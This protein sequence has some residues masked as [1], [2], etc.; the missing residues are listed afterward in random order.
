MW[1]CWKFVMY[2]MTFTSHPL[3]VAGVGTFVLEDSP[4]QCVLASQFLKE[5][6]GY[7]SLMYGIIFGRNY[8][9]VLDGIAAGERKGEI[10]SL[11]VIT[12]M[13]LER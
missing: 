3:V 9:I 4:S 7:L 2:L 13:Q 12:V 6:A 5:T 11:D 10:N 1:S 8:L